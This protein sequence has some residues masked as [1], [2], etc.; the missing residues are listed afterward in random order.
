M[1]TQ[2]TGSW[3]EPGGAGRLPE[4]NLEHTPHADR[5]KTAGGKLMAAGSAAVQK[6][7]CVW[8]AQGTCTNT[9]GI[10]C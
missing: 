10:S 7:L 4:S 9:S 6:Y 1:E 5:P 8:P 2:N 3:E